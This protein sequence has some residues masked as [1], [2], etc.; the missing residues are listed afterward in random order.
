MPAEKSHV[1]APPAAGAATKLLWKSKAA[2]LALAKRSGYKI[3]RID[4]AVEVPLDLGPA[5]AEL[6]QA[7]AP[8]T[9]TGPERIAALRD[10]TR[11]VLAAGV[12]GAFVECGVWRGGSMLAVARTLVEAGVT[13]RDLYL[14]DTFTEMPPPD[15][16]DG[17]ILGNSAADM[18]AVTSTLP[19]YDIW[20]VQRVVD[21]VTRSGYPQER[22][23]PVQGMVEDT[24]PGSAPDQIA[25]LRLDTDW[26]A[27][28]KHELEHLLPLVSSGGICII[29]D[30]GEFVG[31][32]Q[33][34]DEYLEA[35][36]VPVLLH[37]I[38]TTGRMIVVDDRL[39]AAARA[40]R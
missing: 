39:A 10:A 7:V 30:Y 14:F 33:A 19:E 40:H 28:T 12:P 11:H 23:H 1:A 20:P 27:S 34:V 37:R 9:L 2:V 36:G 22:I 29:D 25:L 24:T 18:L 32:R 4:R 21:V 17:D 35:L 13:D 3:E 5:I 6:Y 8:F 15:D 16:I 38:D 26:Y 31:A